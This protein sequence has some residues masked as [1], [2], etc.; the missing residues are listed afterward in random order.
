[1]V[2][3]LELSAALMVHASLKT[4]APALNRIGLDLTA[5]CQCALES[6]RHQK[7]FVQVMVIAH[8][9]TIVNVQVLGQATIAKFQ[10]ALV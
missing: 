3:M 10:Y 6:I 4:C 1:M 2:H 9:R 7:L 8:L 5:P